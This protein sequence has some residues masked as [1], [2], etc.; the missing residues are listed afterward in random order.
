MFFDIMNGTHSFCIK[1]QMKPLPGEAN[2][3]YFSLIDCI[4]Q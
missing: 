3:I 1:F 4:L 2:A